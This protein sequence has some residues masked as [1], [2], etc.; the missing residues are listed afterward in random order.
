MILISGV[1]LTLGTHWRRVVMPAASGHPGRQIRF[2]RPWTPAS[3]GVTKGMS[4]A[5]GIIGWSSGQG[6]RHWHIDNDIAIAIEAR[7][8]AGRNYAGRIVFLDDTRPLGS[9]GE[10]GAV[11]DTSVAPAMDRTEIGL[12]QRLG[13]H[14]ALGPLGLGREG[15]AWYIGDT[16]PDHFEGD[17]PAR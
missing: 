14:N 10:I 12:P 9:L 15:G 2:P 3:A 17:E 6:R 4:I 11:D 16:A 13:D 1:V 8:R 7:D 5:T